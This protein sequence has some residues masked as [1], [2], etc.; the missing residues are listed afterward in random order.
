MNKTYFEIEA[1]TITYRVKDG[2]YQFLVIYRENFDDYSFPK[3]H[4]E[5]KESL[6]EA[7]LR[8][9]TEETGVSAKIE[10]FLD[11]F[12]YQVSEEK[13]GLKADIIRRVYTFIGL[14]DSHKKDFKNTDEK[15]GLTRIE[16]LTYEEAY[17]KLTYENN[18]ALLTKFYSKKYLESDFEFSS[19]CLKIYAKI[20]ELIKQDKTLL[21]AITHLGTVGSVNDNEAV[22]GWSDLDIFIITSSDE[23]G[24]I[25]QDIVMR[26]KKV[27]NQTSSLFPGVE[28]S[29][30]PHTLYD[31][32]NYV[33]YE[34]LK[35]YQFATIRYKDSPVDVRN[36]IEDVLNEREVTQEVRKR[37]AVYRLRHLRFNLIRAVA[38]WKGKD[39]QIAKLIV[40]RIIEIQIFIC[41]Y[42]N[43]FLQ[44]KYERTD[45]LHNLIDDDKVLSIFT[46]MMKIRA[47]W[48]TI[49][50]EQSSKLITEGIESLSIIERYLLAKYPEPVPEE[51]MNPKGK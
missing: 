51:Y 23:F 2:K 3:G 28:I 15:E 10:G 48:P 13:N 39:K 33:A 20:E 5:E 17:Q 41:G 42:N 8:E 49:T 12:E 31:F 25:P 11:S 7:A 9:T 1:G 18:K 21:N 50:E 26:L 40:D 36:Y 14:V 38:S 4:L 29:F 6:E 47:R 46:R 24:N 45:E 30:L 19:F 37:Y 27:H 34:Y 22:Q 16:W 32:K 44:H 35:N 43:V